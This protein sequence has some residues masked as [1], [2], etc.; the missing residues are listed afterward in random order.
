M[1]ISTKSHISRRAFLRGT[2]VALALPWLEAM[3]PAFA[4]RAQAANATAAPKRFVAMTHGL[5]FHGP[6]LFPVE[7][8]SGYT[9]TPYLEAMKEHRKD[10]SVISGLSHPEQNGANGHTCEMTIL[11]AAKHPGLPGFRNTI[12]LDQ[13]LVEK[14]VPDTRM[15]YLA[16]GMGSDS[17]SW[18]ANGVNIPG[19]SSPERLYKTLFVTGTKEETDKQMAELKRGRSILDTVNA[20]AKSLNA[21]LGARDKEKFDQY[22]T[23]VRELE[24]RLQVSQ[25]WVLKP[26]PKVDVPQPKDVQD[27]KDIVARMRLMNE[28]IVLALQ[29]DSTRFVTVK[30]GQLGEVPKIEGVD[31]GWH[32]LSHHGQDAQKIEEL[33]LIEQAE[34]REI[35]NFM[36]MLK[37][38]K[39]SGGTLLD[40]TTLFVTSNLGNASSHSSRDLPVIVAGGGF[41]HGSHIVAGGKGNDNARLSNLYVQIARRFGVDTEAFGTNDGTSVKGLV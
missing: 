26:K 10:F 24:S 37:A 21:Q 36:G 3:V 2:G 13:F 14:L 23:S 31:T 4:T 25:G 35:G 41:K 9:A 12:S 5:G 28:M 8:G 18:T 34:F 29:T 19:E 32:D 33:K 30:T 22:L 39:E 38:A 17:C 16:L 7:E 40:N 27:R 20:R 6:F 15:P 11:T 1:N